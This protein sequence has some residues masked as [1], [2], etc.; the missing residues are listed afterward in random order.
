[1]RESIVPLK[2]KILVADDDWAIVEVLTMILEGDGYEVKGTANEQTLSVIES[3]VPDLLIL[4]IWMVGID[5]RDICKYLKSHQRIK[6]IPVIIISA[7]NNIETL[8]KEASAD[9]FI[10][11]PFDM[12]ELLLKVKEYVQ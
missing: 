8:V 11:K 6:Q 7:N 4:D 3:Y 1:M 5:G 12:D 10:E 2:K 9:D